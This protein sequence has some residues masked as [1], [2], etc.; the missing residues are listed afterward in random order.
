VNLGHK[1]SVGGRLSLSQDTDVES[2]NCIGTGGGGGGGGGG[3][4]WSNDGATTTVTPVAPSAVLKLGTV[5]F[6]FVVGGG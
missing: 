5:V 3:V 2:C 6:G 4:T 1:P